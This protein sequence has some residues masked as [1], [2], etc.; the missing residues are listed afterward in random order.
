MRDYILD[1]DHLLGLMAGNENLLNRLGA[2]KKG[3]ARLGTTVTVVSDLYFLIRSSAQMESNTAALTELLA[4]LCVWG[5]DRGA[6]EISGE[7]LTQQRSLTRPISRIEAEIAAVA[8]QR[9][10]VLLTGGERFAEVRD[11]EVEN[12]LEPGSARH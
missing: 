12:W 6:A 11:I 2:I 4:D 9:Q 5:F 1:I 7:I 8:R 3:E 10:A